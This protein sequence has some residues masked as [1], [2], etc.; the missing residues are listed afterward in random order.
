MKIF[1]DSKKL[2]NYQ[3]SPRNYA[4]F[5]TE[6]LLEVFISLDRANL[7]CEPLEIATNNPSDRFHEAYNIFGR[8]VGNRKVA[9]DTEI[10]ICPSPAMIWNERGRDDLERFARFV[11]DRVGVGDAAGKLLTYV[12]RKPHSLG[13]YFLNE[14]V[15]VRALRD[16]A[17]QSELEFRDV[18]LEDHSFESQLRIIN[19]T[20]ILIGLHGAAF[21]NSIFLQPNSISI[22]F[23][24]NPKFNHFK[25]L[26]ICDLIGVS[27]FEINI[28]KF[29]FP[30][31]LSILRIPVFYI[32]DNPN[33]VRRD[34]VIIADVIK[35]K[36]E[37]S[38][39]LQNGA[40]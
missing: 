20:K 15:V 30:N 11:R 28:N 1:L 8:Y 34:R 38:E 22:Q 9:K 16:I 4:H 18:K 24:P 12:R 13:R 7:L 25:F 14:E 2:R 5:L 29:S 26:Q 27:H 35:L 33:R 39:I 31:F 36:T 37:M 23:W 40:I 6:N 10:T 3:H 21:S 32:G 17:E 19:Q